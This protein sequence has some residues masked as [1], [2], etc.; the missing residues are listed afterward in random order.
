M[1]LHGGTAGAIDVNIGTVVFVLEDSSDNTWLAFGTNTENQ[2]IGACG[3][4]YRVSLSGELDRVAV[5]TVA[6]DTFDA[7]VINIS[8]Q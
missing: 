3:L 4:T 1:D 6:A 2:T 8:Y 5:T 7:G